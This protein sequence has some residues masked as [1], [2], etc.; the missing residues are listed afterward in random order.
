[1]PPSEND[2]LLKLLLDKQKNIEV[3]LGISI[4]NLNIQSSLLK[5]FENSFSNIDSAIKQ[6][7]SKNSSVNTENK[8]LKQLVNFIEKLINDCDHGD[9]ED[10]RNTFQ[11][12]N[13]TLQEYKQVINLN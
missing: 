9:Y 13:K 12:I 3:E 2:K 6:L 1:M 8:V 4:K 7:N 10:V 11:L 5:K